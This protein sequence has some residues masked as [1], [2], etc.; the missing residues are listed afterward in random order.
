M[1]I[2]FVRCPVSIE[3]STGFLFRENR[4]HGTDGQTEK[5]TVGVQRIVRPLGMAA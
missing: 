1:A 3:V 2:A 4:N 5:R